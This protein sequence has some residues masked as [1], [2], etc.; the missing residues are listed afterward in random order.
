MAGLIKFIMSKMGLSWVVLKVWEMLK[1]E[2]VKWAESDGEKDWD[3]ALVEFI[4][5]FV[6]LAVGKLKSEGK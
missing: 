4:D 2:L 5:E 6:Q 1:P 3:D